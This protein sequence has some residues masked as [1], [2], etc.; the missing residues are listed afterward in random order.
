MS[1]VALDT[2]VEPP[3]LVMLR[4]LSAQQIEELPYRTNDTRYRCLD[5]REPLRLSRPNSDSRYTAR[6]SHPGAADCAADAAVRRETEEHLYAKEVIRDWLL[7]VHPE[8]DATIEPGFYGVADG[9]RFCPDVL[10]WPEGRMVGVEYQRASLEVTEAQERVQAYLEHTGPGRLHLWLFSPDP[11]TR[12]FN[13]AG[14]IDTVRGRFPTLAPTRDQRRIV[15]AGGS[16][17]WLNAPL[18]KLYVPFSISEHVHAMR[19]GE[20]WLPTAAGDPRRDWHAADYPGLDPDAPRWGLIQVDLKAC[21]ISK[22]RRFLSTRAH[23]TIVD[24]A[25]AEPAREDRRRADARQAWGE[26]H[27]R[28]E[29]LRAELTRAEAGQGAAVSQLRAQDAAL[30]AAANLEEQAAAAAAEHAQLTDALRCLYR[31]ES[32]LTGQIGRNPI[33]LL[34]SGTRRAT[35][36]ARRTQVRIEISTAANQVLE[37]A[38]TRRVTAQ[39][40]REAHPAGA[41]ARAHAE[42]AAWTAA[43]QVRLAA[44]VD[45]DVAAARATLDAEQSRIAAHSALGAG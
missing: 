14:R 34:L 8:S 28:V 31:Q 29:V 25:H 19:P 27:R 10:A 43:W 3:R 6:F 20:L 26:A 1:E 37:L 12:H 44:A 45:Q 17:Y 7:D 40:A 24:L 42:L 38:Q 16:V 36:L 35:L 4:R 33:A 22:N 5:C 30:R 13:P 23:F 21:K 18:R 15:R 32:R 41:R 2:G 9:R 39:R 11:K